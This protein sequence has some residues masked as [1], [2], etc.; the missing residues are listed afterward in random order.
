M[1]TQKKM[2]TVKELQGLFGKTR[3]V[4]SG[5][6]RGLTVAELTG[7]RRRL[8]EVNV[9]V[10]VVKN[11]LARIAAANSGHETFNE[12]IEGPTALV[13]GFGDEVET[14]RAL[15]EYLRT[16]RVNFQV[17]GAVLEGKAIGAADVAALATLPPR[18]VLI[19]QIV[20]GMQSPITGLVWTLNSVLSSV[21]RV[22]D[23][24]AKQM[25]GS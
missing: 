19:A 6:Y 22:L 10:H 2:E 18:Q 16:S 23:A 5:D 9:E 12:I 4:I 14:A 13:L 20:G 1:P 8:R 15:T 21:V 3:V 25:A 24:R 7:M 17:R 11:S